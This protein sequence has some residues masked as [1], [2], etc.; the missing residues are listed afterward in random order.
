MNRFVVDL[1]ECPSV[2]RTS[3]VARTFGP[4]MSEEYSPV[5]FAGGGGL[6][7]MHRLKYRVSRTQLWCLACDWW[8]Q[9]QLCLSRPFP[10]VSSRPLFLGKVAFDAVGLGVGP[11]SFRVDSEE[12]LLKR[13]DERAPLARAAPGATPEMKLVTKSTNGMESMKY[14]P[15]MMAS[16]WMPF[17]QTCDEESGDAD[18]DSFKMS[19]WDAGGTQR[20]ELHEVM[21]RTMVHNV[22]IWTTRNTERELA[23]KMLMD[24][25]CPRLTMTPGEDDASYRG[26][27]IGGELH[28]ILAI[29]DGHT[30]RKDDDILRRS[31]VCVEIDI[32]AN[33][34]CAEIELNDVTILRRRLPQR[35]DLAEHIDCY[36]SHT[37]RKDDD[38]LRRSAVCV[39]IDVPADMNCTTAPWDAG[40]TQSDKV[41]EAMCRAMVHNIDRLTIKEYRM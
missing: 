14:V 18:F 33:M 7:P 26:T 36:I 13:T 3:A 29:S 32:P 28:D 15:Q 24:T 11:P 25:N 17:K 1:V 31:A 21:C 2:S 41:H 8:C 38:I 39:E 34:N 9:T 16:V 10:V 37:R 40:G 27:Q 6:L 5:V 20:D 30:R 19:P 22:D 35:Q 12:A 23:T 4:A